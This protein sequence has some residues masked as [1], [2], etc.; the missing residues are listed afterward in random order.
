[1]SAVNFVGICQ[2]ISLLAANVSLLVAL[3]RHGQQ[4]HLKLIRHHGHLISF[5]FLCSEFCSFLPN[6]TLK[7]NNK[8]PLAA[9]S[10]IQTKWQPGNL[11]LAGACDAFSLCKSPNSTTSC[12]RLSA[13]TSHI[14][15][16]CWGT[17][18]WP[19]CLSQPI[20]SR[21]WPAVVGWR[22]LWTP[23]HGHKESAAPD[24]GQPGRANYDS[25]SHGGE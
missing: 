9:W 17:P 7:N 21:V 6:L 20:Y 11:M 15:T 23:L 3:Q 4:W 18:L 14:H 22:K 16:R 24:K 2:D 8:P 13:L 19:V 1:M 25:I 10:E 12:S 5:I